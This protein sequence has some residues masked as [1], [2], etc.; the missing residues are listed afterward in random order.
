MSRA[1]CWRC[2][3]ENVYNAEELTNIHPRLQCDKKCSESKGLFFNSMMVVP[4][5]DEI[6]LGVIQVINLRDDAVFTKEDLK[7]ANMVAQS[8]S[9]SPV[10]RLCRVPTSPN[11]VCRRTASAS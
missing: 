9:L 6:L 10:S 2:C 11:A 1:T 7:H 5:K 4:I 8:S 3:V